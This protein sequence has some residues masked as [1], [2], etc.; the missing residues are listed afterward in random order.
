MSVSGCPRRD[1]VVEAVEDVVAAHEADAELAAE[2]ELPR[3]LQH[4]LGAAARIHAAGV[5]GDPDAALDDIGKNPLH[6]RHEVPRVP[7]ARD[8]GTSVSA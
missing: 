3:D 2:P 1:E 5:R 4:R 6:Q 8:R 7:C